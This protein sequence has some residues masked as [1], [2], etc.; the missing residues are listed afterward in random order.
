MMAKCNFSIKHENESIKNRNILNAHTVQ[1]RLACLN[2]D[3][4]SK[5]VHC[6]DGQNYHDGKVCSN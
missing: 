4:K 3:R 2:N 5:N 1:Y 6:V